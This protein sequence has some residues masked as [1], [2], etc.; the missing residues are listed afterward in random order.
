VW[1]TPPGIGNDAFGTKTSQNTVYARGRIAGVPF[2]ATDCKRSHDD[3]NAQNDSQN[4]DDSENLIRPHGALWL[5]L[6]SFNSKGS[7][8]FAF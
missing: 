6:P 4:T 3:A 1:L 2:Q 8:V 5:C 7:I